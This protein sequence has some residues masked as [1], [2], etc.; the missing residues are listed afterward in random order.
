MPSTVLFS[1]GDVDVV[2]RHWVDGSPVL[3]RPMSP[4]LGD[5]ASSAPVVTRQR[6]APGPPA[7]AQLRS[8]KQANEGCRQAQASSPDT[9]GFP[10][11]I[12]DRST[13]GKKGRLR[14]CPRN[15][16]PGKGRAYRNERRGAAGVPLV[17]AGKVFL[18][19]PSRI[20]RARFCHARLGSMHTATLTGFWAEKK[21]RIRGLLPAALCA[22]LVPETS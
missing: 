21:H 7:P 20:F 13:F 3:P 5:I 9:H 19:P 12:D 16:S 22:S 4:V 6:L 17:L 15:V 2:H 18:I 10:S 11:T 14:A 8:Q 1:L